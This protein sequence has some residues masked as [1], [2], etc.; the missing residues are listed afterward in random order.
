MHD[1]VLKII[2]KKNLIENIFNK[3]EK[4]LLINNI[5]KTNQKTKKGYIILLINKVK[6][7]SFLKI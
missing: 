1:Y 7:T 4:C 3:N 6:K 5:I 2:R